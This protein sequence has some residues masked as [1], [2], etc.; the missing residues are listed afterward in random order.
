M[1][2]TAAPPPELLLKAHLSH[3]Q[4]SYLPCCSNELLR[5]WQKDCV[6]TALP[7]IKAAQSCVCMQGGAFS[8]TAYSIQK[9]MLV[10]SVGA[11]QSSVYHSVSHLGSWCYAPAAAWTSMLLVIFHRSQSLSAKCLSASLTYL[12]HDPYSQSYGDC[13]VVSSAAGMINT[14]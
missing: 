13:R 12:G 5:H 9:A 14:I 4:V 3:L 6:T 11:P 1:D 8:L 10:V 7:C 2:T